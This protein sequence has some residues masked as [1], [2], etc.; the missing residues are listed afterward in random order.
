[1]NGFKTFKLFKS[2]K[3]P[4]S[5]P[6]VAWEE[7]SEGWNNWNYLNGWNSD[8]ALGHCNAHLSP[9]KSARR[10]FCKASANASLAWR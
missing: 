2:F 5:S 8:E 10:A 6:R 4:P 7:T 1:M 9:S 3:P